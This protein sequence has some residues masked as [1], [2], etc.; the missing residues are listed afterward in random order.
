M[1]GDAY[2]TWGRLARLDFGAMPD[3]FDAIVVGGGTAGSVVAARLVEAG[4]RV[5]VLEAGP[6][7]GS[8]GWLGWPS[9]L[10]DAATIPTSHDWGYTSGDEMSDR[11]LAYE[12]ARVIGGCSAH[13]GCTVSWGHRLDYDGWVA[14]GLEGWAA[15]D[16]LPLF[17]EAS[18]KMRV[19]R[20]RD[21]EI[22]PLH[23]SFIEAGVAMGLP[24][25]DDLE[26]LDGLP[27]VCAEPSNSPEGIRWNAAFAY[28]DPVRDRPELQIRGN[29]RAARVEFEAGRAVGIAFIH[30]GGVQQAWA[31]LI[32]IAAG[33]YGT[34]GLLL[35]SGVGPA[36]DLWDIGIDIVADLPGVGRNLHDHPAFE[37]HFDPT[38]DLVARTEAF[39]ST[40]MPVPDEQAFA[41]VASSR[42]VDGVFDLHLFP[43][44][45]MDRRPAIFAACLTPR[46]RGALTLRTSD[47]DATPRVD[48]AYLTDEEDHDLAVLAEGV[49]MARAFASSE[50]MRPLLGREREPGPDASGGHALVEAIRAG[51][52][53]YWHPVGTC[54]MGPATDP[55]AV[56]DTG[57]KVRGVEGLVVADASL[58]PATVRATTNLPTIVIGERIAS[59]LV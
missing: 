48:H 45:A 35:H 13:N 15:D 39:S 3:D 33:T 58:M 59:G 36:Q 27:S 55:D 42:A 7:H 20:F 56:T 25:I 19:R 16:L 17:A 6:D 21:D 12:R 53:H 43:E 10:L 5:L 4:R 32:V 28:L 11:Q 46:S 57:G 29:A 44:V 23:R 37:L 22:T 31:D 1:N 2:S 30:D 49:D 8:F 50:A 26:S 38:D 34:P 24:E 40:G 41:K 9:D 14:R 52:I 54:A 18:L 51:V 47:P